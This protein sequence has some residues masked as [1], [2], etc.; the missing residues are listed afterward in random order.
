[1]VISTC[2]LIHTKNVSLDL[3]YLFEALIQSTFELRD[4]SGTVL[5]DTTLNVI[6][7]Q[8][9]IDLNLMFQLELIC[10][11]ELLLSTSR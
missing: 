3:L 10:N 2:C 6:A 9:R 7:G 8:Q 4:N 1:M 5:D 11:L